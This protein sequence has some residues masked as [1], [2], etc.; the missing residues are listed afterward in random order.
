MGILYTMLVVTGHG[1]SL[2][3]IVSR[4][5]HLPSVAFRVASRSMLHSHAIRSLC[6]VVT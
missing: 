2:H 5:K 6:G 3:C 4:T 1:P